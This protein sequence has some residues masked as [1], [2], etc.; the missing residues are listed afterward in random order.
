MRNRELINRKLD[1]LD[2]TLINLQRI[3]NT[4]EPLSTYKEGIVKA[5]GIIE[6]LKSMVEREPQSSGEQNSSVR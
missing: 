3:V 4:Q 1:Q 5:Q 2:H 6:D